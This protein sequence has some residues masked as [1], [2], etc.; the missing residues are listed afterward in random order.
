MPEREPHG[1]G[2]QQ[3]FEADLGCEDRR[4]E[5]AEQRHGHTQSPAGTSV[6]GAGAD[7]RHHDLPRRVLLRL[8]HRPLDAQAIGR[9]EERGRSDP[10]DLPGRGGASGE[11]ARRST[12]EAPLSASPRA[13]PG[14]Q[15]SESGARERRQQRPAPGC[16]QQPG[17]AH[18]DADGDQ[19][20]QGG[21][22]EGPKRQS[23][24]SSQERC[25]GDLR[26]RLGHVSSIQRGSGDGTGSLTPQAPS[27]TL[28]SSGRHAFRTQLSDL[29]RRRARWR[30]TRSRGTRPSAPTAGRRS[31]SRAPGK[32]RIGDGARGGLLSRIRRPG[33]AAS[34]SGA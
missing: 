27:P 26:D 6:L 15:E 21:P 23:Q 34:F 25:E 2:S 33:P 20:A 22:L 18:P 17:D 10:G 31:P 5:E 16:V 7:H 3:D 24:Q 28:R 14:R 1:L 12:R 19:R 29:Q 11:A 8:E 4:P 32:T 9:V 30:A 13:E